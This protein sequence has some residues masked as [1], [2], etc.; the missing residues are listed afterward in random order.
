MHML[1]SPAIV[2]HV[3]HAVHST[4][5]R[6]QHRSYLKQHGY[7][8]SQITTFC[9]VSVYYDPRNMTYHEW[10][11]VWIGCTKHGARGHHRLQ[12]IN[13]RSSVLPRLASCVCRNIRNTKNVCHSCKTYIAIEWFPSQKYL[14]KNYT[15]ATV[16]T[17]NGES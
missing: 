16:H 17:C 2:S 11:L 6:S 10:L 7:K 14:S 4:C 9:L 5:K 1:H 13:R 12:Q 15:V 8:S 3:L